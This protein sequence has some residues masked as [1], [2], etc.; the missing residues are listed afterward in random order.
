MIVLIAIAPLAARLGNSPTQG[1][2]GMTA[3]YTIPITWG[4]YL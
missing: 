4:I 1:E 2:R 3:V